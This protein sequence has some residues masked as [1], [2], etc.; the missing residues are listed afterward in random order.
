M[1]MCL[2]LDSD[3]ISSMARLPGLL[4]SIPLRQQ[5]VRRLIHAIDFE[6]RGSL[7]SMCFMITDIDTEITL[8]IFDNF[9]RTVVGIVFDFGDDIFGNELAGCLLIVRVIEE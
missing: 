2:Y 5:L 7:C 6:K 3:V 8:E 1:K 4:S 9:H